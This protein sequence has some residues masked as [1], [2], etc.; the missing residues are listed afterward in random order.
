MQDASRFKEPL[1]SI[2]MPC[3]NAEGYIEEALRSVLLQGCTSLELMVVDGGSTDRTVDIIKRYEPWLSWWVSEKDRGQSHAINK[4]L[5]RA[6]GEL[7]NWFNADDVLCPGAL[8]QLAEVAVRHPEA[9]G[10]CG[11]MSMFD[12]QGKETILDPVN[13]SREQLAFWCDP[14]FLPQPASLYR[15]ALCR[16]VGGVDERLHY[17]MDM[18]L[19]LK[20][21]ARGAFVT[22]EKVCARF[23]VHSGSKTMSNPNAVLMETIAT[24]HNLGLD[25][26]ATEL[27]R[28]RMERHAGARIAE[29]T[30]GD[31][32]K[33]VDE[34]S[35]GKGAL[36]IGRRLAR[37][38]LLRLR[39]VGDGSRRAR[40][41]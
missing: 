18:D 5:A 3:L 1:I 6:S 28:R 12:S 25:R 11:A 13:G 33:R 14:Y 23:R 39:G 27:L 2:V 10:V 16:E 37:S 24:N 20:L 9:V 34:W 21:A 4:G 30:E 7:F 41:C 15:T 19:V 32:A 29:L 36:Y 17:V 8:L 26:V 38:V 31:I 35:L 22:T 40:E